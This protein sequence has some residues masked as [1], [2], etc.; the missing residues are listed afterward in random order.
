MT[1]RLIC[2]SCTDLPLEEQSDPRLLRVPLGIQLGPETVQ[3]DETLQQAVLLEKM[4]SWPDA[5]KTACPSPAE[6]L[7][8]FLEGGDNYVVTLSGR[9]SG[10]YNAAMQARAIYREEGGKG[11]VHVFNSRSASAGQ[12]QIALLIRELAEGGMPFAQIVERV[13]A[14]INRM[15]TLFVLENLDNLRKN[16]RLTKMQSLVTG[17][18]RVKLLCGS[19]PEGEIEKLGQG[20]S[21]RQAL[22]RMISR[23][24]ADS[25]H[26]GRRLV[27]AH[28]N[29]PDR[30]VYVRDLARSRC[31][32]GSILLAA[33]GGITTVYAND[34]GI[35]TAY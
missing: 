22:A 2:D 32:F 33:A 25:G 11:N 24:A 35:V 18:L 17:A 26:V 16:G 9:L 6:Y 28:C 30:A 34:G 14:Y 12:T 21:V 5:P 4:K 29:C 20:L 1:Y 19:T 27:I 23:M 7:R 15:K 10:S 31:Q 8:H 3:D 13:E